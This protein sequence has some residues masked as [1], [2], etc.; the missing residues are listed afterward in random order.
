MDPHLCELPALSTLPYLSDIAEL[1]F[2]LAFN[3]V[4]LSYASIYRQYI[5][6]SY[7]V[8]LIIVPL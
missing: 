1:Y 2:S 3:S 8:S 4:T 7:Q 6:F 5:E